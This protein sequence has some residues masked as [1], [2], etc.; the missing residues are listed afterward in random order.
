[1]SVARH[2]TEWLELVPH[3][4]PFV[5]MTALL[6]VFPQGLDRRDPDTARDLVRAFQDW[7]FDTAAPGKQRAWVL[8]V[9]QNFLGWSPDLLVE[10]Q[11]MPPGLET[12]ILEHGE[13]LRPDLVLVGPS[14]TPSA[15]KPHLLIQVLNPD[16]KSSK[17]LA[18][19]NWKASPET[20]MAELL[21]A[22]NNPLGLI[23]NGEEWTLVF[24]QRGE[25]PGFAHWYSTLWIEE[26]IT[27]RGFQSLLDQRRFFGVAENDTLLGMLVA[28]LDDQAEVTTS[29]GNQVR[30][31]VEVLIRAFDKID[32]DSHG[33]LLT[34]VAEKALYDASLTL[35]MR[36]VFLFSAEERGLLDLGKPLYDRNYAVSTLR[37]QLQEIAD[38]FGEEVLERR[39]D[40]WARLLAIFR[41]VHSGVKHQDLPIPEYQG[42]LF[43]PDRFPFLEG[44]PLN[45]K[46]ESTTANPLPI[47]NRV[48]L[49]LLTS[50]QML[51]MKLPG[52]GPATL[53]RVSF[54]GLDIEQIGH[55]YE[56]LL[57]YTAARATEPLLGL[58][59]S[60]D[61][62]IPFATLSDLES[63]RSQGDEVLIEKLSEITKRTPATLKRAI[64]QPATINGPKLLIACHQD[65]TVFERAV[66]FASL[67]R[68]DSFEQPVVILPQGIHIAK[69]TDRRSTGTH[70]TPRSLTEP[71][72]Q[73]TLEPLVY[74]G[75][76]EGLPKQEW[77][78]RPPKEILNLKVCDMA[79]GS[80]AFL[81]QTCRYLAERLVESWEN[82]E[83]AHPGEVLIT[84][85]GDFSK[86][87]V[88]DRLIPNEPEERIA[89]ARRL[90]TDRCLY[91]VD[92]NPM[93]VEMAKLSLWLITVQRDR[94]FTFLDH[95]FKCG[96]SLLGVT[97]IEQIANFSLRPG[98]WPVTFAMTELIGAVQFASVMRSNLAG[99]SSNDHAQIENKARLNAEVEA[100]TEKVKLL[101]DCLVA[102]ELCNLE[103]EEY[104]A[105]RNKYAEDIE[106]ELRN[107]PQD[108]QRFTAELLNGRR[109]FH[110]PLE[111]SEVFDGGGF[112]AFIGNPPFLG[113]VRISEVLSVEYNKYLVERTDGSNRKADLCCYFFRRAAS[114]IRGGG[115]LGLIATNSIT[116]GLNLRVALEYLCNMGF[117]IYIASSSLKWPGAGA[118]EVSVIHLRS[119]SWIGPRILDG[120][121]ES[122]ISPSLTSQRT[123][124]AKPLLQNVGK[125]Y[126]GPFVYGDGFLLTVEESRSMISAAPENAEV[127]LPY[128]IGQDIN[129]NKT[130][131]PSRYVISFEERTEEEAR[132]YFLPFGRLKRDVFP[133]RNAMN[134]PARDMRVKTQW[135]KF[136]HPRLTLIEALKR[137]DAV[138]ARSQVSTHHAVA[139]VPSALIPSHFVI[140]FLG[141]VDLVFPIIQ[142]GFHE[143]WVWSTASSLGGFNNTRYIQRDCFQ[144]FPFPRNYFSEPVLF[145]AVVTAGRNY[146]EHRKQ[147]LLSREEGLTKM[148]NRFHDS[149]DESSDI[150]QLRRLRIEMDQAVLDAYGWS[151]LDLDH[152]FHET[153][154]SVR[155]TF[156]ESAR[157][158]VLNR[159][160]ALNHQRYAD[161]VSAGLHEKKSKAK[162]SAKMDSAKSKN[163]KTNSRADVVV[164]Q[165][166]LFSSSGDNESGE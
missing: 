81:V 156:N 87:S 2:H 31:A 26:Q 13:T 78:L 154:K 56:G 53:R 101:A 54:R 58:I 69:G 103:G 86:G 133:I 127:I 37:E 114:L 131:A 51:R 62:P 74:I 66:R 27:L 60:K 162:K 48:V 97:T 145:A 121:I 140:V 146:H 23:T 120:Q 9:F 110:W 100:A 55:V 105:Q 17:V 115:Y 14:G 147:I 38:Q 46:W 63:W 93:A 116:Q 158:E 155:Y 85:E 138:C 124:P 71:I 44:R 36:L 20:R 125:V 129:G 10:G 136:F 132:K 88:H 119:G 90:I 70:Y 35:M 134:P 153:K 49:H 111:F 164:A 61:I 135:W 165:Q 159:L 72:V 1:M 80:G 8:N 77:K 34:G 67:I 106:A 148:Y 84:P 166:E 6:R 39:S 75:P 41:A 22:T 117:T 25:T 122:D 118:V 68:N 128:L 45:S 102:F 99:L 130:H 21:R 3:S 151:G 82:A 161:E 50:L 137:C 24:A 91:G 79:M 59:G 92:I 16:Q 143:E 96:D 29:L 95:A 12:N 163:K 107:S 109:P 11:Q 42:S 152:G 64:A 139:I 19:K 144:T 141:P 89:I 104:E 18:N 28:S 73:H 98:N 33:A 149:A 5:S 94:P 4:G 30:D 157:R 76:A 40:G 52:G 112:D 83:A 57:D 142:S 15:G 7:Q 108:F 43:D 160:L 32:Q 126:A 113:G 47:N 123:D 65:V 150:A